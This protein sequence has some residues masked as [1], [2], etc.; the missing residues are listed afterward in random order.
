MIK[1]INLFVILIFI[2]KLRHISYAI[3]VLHH[4]NS[5]NKKDKN[6]LEQIVMSDSQMP[7]L[8][9][10]RN[11]NNEEVNDD[12]LTEKINSHFDEL[13]EQTD[14]RLIDIHNKVKPNIN[15]H[16]K[17]TKHLVKENTINSQVKAI[18]EIDDSK[19]EISIELNKVNQQTYNTQN[20]N[21]F[22]EALLATSK[23]STEASEKI[24]CK[25]LY[26]V[27]NYF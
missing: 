7:E 18:E 9:T 23:T 16:V 10:Q 6:S 19:P 15:D 20:K 25:F 5:F 4:E 27:S 24:E 22:Q 8:M 2:L 12:F 21:H 11:E 14:Y 1:C 3:Q 17:N 26:I 13:G